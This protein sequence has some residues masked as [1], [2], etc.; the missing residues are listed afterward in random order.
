MFLGPLASI[1][2]VQSENNIYV[3]EENTET[4]QASTSRD[5]SDMLRAFTLHVNVLVNQRRH[6]DHRMVLVTDFSSRRNKENGIK[7]E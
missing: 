3:T 2:Y 1:C 4:G 5:E 7:T 6:G